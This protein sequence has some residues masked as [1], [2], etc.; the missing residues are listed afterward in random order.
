MEWIINKDYI[1][2]KTKKFKWIKNIAGFDLDDTLIKT[3]S[4]KKFANESNDWIFQF[5]NVVEKI[6][7]ISKTHSI[8]ILSN[9]AGIETKKINSQMWINKLD[10]IVKKL[11]VEIIILCASAKNNYRKPSIGFKQLF[12]E[13]SDK[14]FYCGD[15]CGRPCDFSDT[16]YK[17][18]LNCKL[19]FFTPEHFF[20]NVDNKVPRI[21]QDILLTLK[22]NKCIITVDKNEEP[23]KKYTKLSNLKFSNKNEMIIMT[24][25]QGSGKSYISNYIHEKYG[26]SIINQDIL[27][28]VAKCKKKANEI[29]K[30]KTGC[31]IDATNPGDKIKKEWIELAKKYEYDV[32]IIKMNT[33]IEIS[34]HNNFYR[35]FYQ[36][37]KLIPDIAYNMYKKYYQEPSFDN[38]DIDKIITV[39]LDYPYNNEYYQYFS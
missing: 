29:T 22:N 3:K 30:A 17:F 28:T 34:K 2:G 21:K 39:D 14:S 24:G 9:Q 36:D 4:G 37:K 27:G 12:G 19:N 38:L 35:S 10:D 23:Q 6:K 20:K 18:A 13:V 26:H 15:A 25:F 5:D 33:K 7:N 16:D 11:D 1:I 8:F 31:I 32:T